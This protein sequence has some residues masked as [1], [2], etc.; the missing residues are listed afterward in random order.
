VAYE[1]NDAHYGPSHQRKSRRFV[2]RINMGDVDF[3]PSRE[4]VMHTPWTT[5][6]LRDLH[7]YIGFH[8]ERVL[9][10]RLAQCPTRWDETQLKVHWKGS[11]M[12]V[13]ASQ[14]QP[15]WEYT[16]D[17]WRKAR[18][19]TSYHYTY[20]T[21]S[22][23]LVVTG[24]PNKSL[25]PLHRAR[26]VELSPDTAQF[27]V[28]P[29]SSDSSGLSGRDNVFTWDEVIGATDD[30]STKSAR[31]QRGKR[32]ETRY[33]V[34]GSTPLTAKELAALGTQV[35][36]VHSNESAAPHLDCVTVRLYS[37]NQIG[38]LTRMVPGIKPYS[39]EVRE[40]REAAEAA[41]TDADHRLVDA[42][43]LH[44]TFSRLDAS[45]ITD[46]ELAEAIRQS[47]APNNARIEA[48]RKLGVSVGRNNNPT[49]RFVKRYPLLDPSQQYYA[50]KLPVE[51]MVIYINSKFGGIA[52]E[53]AS[54]EMDY[55]ISDDALDAA[56]S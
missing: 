35:L 37:S 32:E 45:Q 54:K 30:P 47:S 31:T 11:Q 12:R 43:N 15:I 8:F 17:G 52:A 19:H 3:A 53:Q 14:S 44:Q 48:A 7:E 1:V 9:N 29:Q 38:R 34:V 18:A 5:E 4:A 26:L 16:P 21:D 33:S 28:I 10:E 56:A 24:F 2:A 20:L 22:K 36:Y 46:P 49:K 50:T 27:I 23:V 13:N 42:R 39:Q 25:S 40:R 6:T 41:L 55:E 51:D